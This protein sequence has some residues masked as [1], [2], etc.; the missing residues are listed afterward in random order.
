MGFIKSNKNKLNSKI[1]R[2][3][4]LEPN[5]MICR[6]K[7]RRLYLREIKYY[8]K[9]EHEDFISLKSSIVNKK[10]RRLQGC[11]AGCFEQQFSVFK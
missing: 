6:E 1:N 11:L 8:E 7:K 5:K 10:S 9:K 2:L 3:I 4:N